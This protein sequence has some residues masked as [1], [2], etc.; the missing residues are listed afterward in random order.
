MRS[1]LE[2]FTVGFEMI[3]NRLFSLQ[4]SIVIVAL[5]YKPVGQNQT[6]YFIIPLIKC[7]QL[8]YSATGDRVPCSFQ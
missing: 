2:P 5:L 4:H 8:V 1:A 3:R 7:P 6:L